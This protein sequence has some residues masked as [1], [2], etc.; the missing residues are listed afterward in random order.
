MQLANEEKYAKQ[1]EEKLN[2]QKEKMMAR[3]AEEEGGLKKVFEEVDSDGTGWLDMSE[4]AEFFILIGIELGDE[5]LHA[6]MSHIDTDSRG[7]VSFEE[8][9]DWVQS[10]HMDPKGRAWIQ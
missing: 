8:L 1:F 3:L 2:S 6:A 4:L 9:T 5:E 10:N 7:A